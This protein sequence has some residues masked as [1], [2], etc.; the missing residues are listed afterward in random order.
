[1]VFVHAVVIACAE[2]QGGEREVDWTLA[3][4]GARSWAVALPFPQILDNVLDQRVMLT[5]PASAGV[6]R[7]SPGCGRPRRD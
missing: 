2:V 1:M 6:L 4:L 3:A 7:A 5:G